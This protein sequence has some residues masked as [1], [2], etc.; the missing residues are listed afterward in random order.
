M[1]KSK[2]AART[3]VR[4]RRRPADQEQMTRLLIVGG[5][6]A[7]IAIAAGIIGFGWYQTK[8]KPLGKT[9]LQVGS[10]KYSLGALERR[11]ELMRDES[12]TY[13]DGQRI[14]LLPRD[15]MDQLTLEAKTLQGASQLKV[16]ITD[17]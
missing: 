9:V 13:Y 16:T 2:T 17:E 14:L 6:I 5:V 1:A 4:H 10:M 11:M 15:T 8:I 3:E 12:A 7:V